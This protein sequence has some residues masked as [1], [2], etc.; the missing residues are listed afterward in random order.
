MIDKIRAAM[1]ISSV[2]ALIRTLKDYK[3][4]LSYLQIEAW[5]GNFLV[6]YSEHPLL[7]WSTDG[8]EIL[9]IHAG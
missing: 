9:S 3:W 1:D 7:L 4:V 5:L 8:L 2:F 6:G